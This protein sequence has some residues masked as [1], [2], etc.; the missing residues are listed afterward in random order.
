MVD[1]IQSVHPSSVTIRTKME[2]ALIPSL[3]ACHLTSGA[4]PHAARITRW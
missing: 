3:I 2:V 1:V 4:D